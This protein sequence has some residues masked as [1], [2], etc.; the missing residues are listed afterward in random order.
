MNRTAAEGLTVKIIYRSL[1]LMSLL[2]LI[3]SS[4]SPANALELDPPAEV[5]DSS[6]RF[7][8]ELQVAQE[9]SSSPK[10]EEALEPAE[11]EEDMIADPL[12]P[13]NRAF[14]HFNDKLYFW[15]LRPVAS[16]YKAVIPQDLRVGVRNFF[17]NLVTPVRLVN[18]LLQANF[19]GA[20]IETVR[21]LMNTGFGMVGFMDLAK[22][23]FH[24][25]KKDED[26]GQTL[27]VWGLGPAI[28]INWPIL[29]PSSVRD[30]IGF[31]G[32]LFLDPR[33]YLIT[34]TPI[35]VGIRSY[36]RV[37]D[38]SLRIGEYEDL[39]KDSLDPYVALKDAYYQYRKN[40]IKER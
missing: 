30:T 38:S 32:D 14:F 13:I 35:N 7:G 39:K 11:E 5:P 40:K 9:T 3:L 1:I 12:E 31:T 26:F 6:F 16:G 37:N 25:E 19:K 29:G 15:V 2:Y 4:I 23:D 17:T 33:N 20:G 10:T 21:F 24:L 36:E 22:T 18:C 8:P 28:Y 34:S 27:G